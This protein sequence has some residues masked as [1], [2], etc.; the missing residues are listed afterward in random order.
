MRVV[1]HKVIKG[2]QGEEIRDIYY[3]TAEEEE[4]GESRY[5]WIIKRVD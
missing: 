3:V 5:D 1:Q 4:E 2:R